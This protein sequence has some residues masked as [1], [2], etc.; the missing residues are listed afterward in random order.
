MKRVIRFA[1]PIAALVVCA[2]AHADTLSLSSVGN[3][4]LT[5]SPATGFTT[6]AE[7][8][9]TFT[10]VG[11][12]N[13]GVLLKTSETAVFNGPTQFLSGYTSTADL[14]G[15]GLD[16]MMISLATTSSTANQDGTYSV[17]GNWV[18]D[19]GT[20][21]YTGLTGGGTFGASFDPT[22]NQLKLE[23]VVGNLQAAPEPVA[24]ATLAIGVVGLIKRKR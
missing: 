15:S 7:T 19:S 24:I 13:L 9:N 20:G 18:Y 11:T 6:N 10:A 2:G 16:A 14:T 3:Y 23:S 17:S 12:L 22:F 21:S 1:A 5:G 8:I 4:S